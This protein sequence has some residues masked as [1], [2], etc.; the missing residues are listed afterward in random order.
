MSSSRRAGYEVRVEDGI[1]SETNEQAAGSDKSKGA[2][3]QEVTHRQ[4]VTE[5][6]DEHTPGGALTRDQAI[7]S[8]GNTG[9]SR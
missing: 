5:A 1:E 9:P 6:A 3:R 8:A 7:Q 4:E 2:A